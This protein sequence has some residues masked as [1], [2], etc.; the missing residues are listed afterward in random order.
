M[1]ERHGTAGLESYDVSR[2]WRPP[3][4]QER[5][6]VRDRS[7]GVW[8]RVQSIARFL[9]FKRAAALT[10]VDLDSV[11]YTECRWSD[12]VPLCLVEVAKDVGQEKQAP[13]MARLAQMA[14][15]P[16]YIALYRPAVHQNPFD[17]A[18][19]GRLTAAH[20]RELALGSPC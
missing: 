14:D 4:K 10:M 8:H 7:Y 11:L 19:P 9:G 12:K 15:I 1:A 17:P 2:L 5:Y 6:A 13:V 16:A 18:W 20:G 3:G